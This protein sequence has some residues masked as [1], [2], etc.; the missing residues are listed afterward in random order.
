VGSSLLQRCEN[1]R[2]G[3]AAEL[4]TADVSSELVAGAR[5]LPNGHLELRVANRDSVQARLGGLN[6]AALEP[7]RGLY[8]TPEALRRLADDADLALVRVDSPRWGQ[9]QVWMW[10]TIVNAF[11]FNDNFATRARAGLLHPSG[12]VARLKYAIDAIVTVLAT[13]LVLVVS[14]PLELFA[15]LAGKGGVLV[16]VAARSRGGRV[17]RR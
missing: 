17:P 14:I 13:P 6:W 1:C 4:R 12:L 3:I 5:S 11:T 8:P 10:Q 7:G 2:L 15:A 9:G 16:A